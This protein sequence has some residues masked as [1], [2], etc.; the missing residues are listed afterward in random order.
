MFRDSVS[1]IR[2]VGTERET[3]VRMIYSFIGCF[4][5]CSSGGRIPVVSAQM[6]TCKRGPVNHFFFIKAVYAY[7]GLSGGDI[8]ARHVRNLMYF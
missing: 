6:I 5:F 1:R 7:R 2:S 3:L 4:R 8:L